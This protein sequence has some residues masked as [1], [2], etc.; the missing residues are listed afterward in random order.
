MT[1]L[2][3]IILDK[4]IKLNEKIYYINSLR[5]KFVCIGNLPN[6]PQLNLQILKEVRNIT[7]LYKELKKEI[8]LLYDTQVYKDIPETEKDILEYYKELL[9]NK[10]DYHNNEEYNNTHSDRYKGRNEND[11]NR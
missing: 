5:Y 4:Y 2:T 6:R 7:S 1:G 3:K 10:V 11:N 9:S 8:D